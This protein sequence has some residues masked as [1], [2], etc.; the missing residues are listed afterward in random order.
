MTEIYD[1][2][3][4]WEGECDDIDKMKTLITGVESNFDSD[5]LHN[6]IDSYLMNLNIESVLD[7]GAGLGRNLP[8]LKKYSQSVDYLD[9]HVYEKNYLNYINDLG[10]SDKFFIEQIPKLEKKYDL[11]YASVV[12]QHIID[13][14]V[15]TSIIKELW[16]HTDYLLVV[17]N[18]KS[19]IKP[20]FNDYFNLEIGKTY[21]N[22]FKD[23]HTYSIYKSIKK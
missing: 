6:S 16:E 4:N 18:R 20:V 14:D 19:P 12:L 22:M 17:Q 21:R 1:T 9:L 7:Y 23:A 8:L 10:Y 15:Y 13:D 2:Y 11:I 3:Y 5:K